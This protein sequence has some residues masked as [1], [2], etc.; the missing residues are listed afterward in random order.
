MRKFAIIA[1]IFIPLAFSSPALAANPTQNANVVH[2]V[3]ASE[4]LSGIASIYHVTV[5]DIVNYNKLSNPDKLQIGQT[6]LIPGKNNNLSTP[7]AKNNE[8]AADG[9]QYEK[10]VVK[11][12]DTFTSIART[13]GV[14]IAD[15]IAA[16]K[17]VNPNALQI[18]Q[19]LLI[20]VSK[21]NQS[22]ASRKDDRTHD[23][24]DNNGNDPEEA[25]A[26]DLAAEIIDYAEEFLGYPYSYAAS[27]PDSFDC[28][29]F[30]RFVFSHFEIDL[31]HSSADQA[32]EGDRVKQRDLI[33]GDLVF[34]KT[35]GRGISHVGIYI[36]DGDFIHASTTSKG[37]IISALS[38]EYYESRYVTAR[39]V[40]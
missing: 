13:E 38:E 24:N 26:D 15:I 6:L 18:G 12:R 25:E 16:N 35:S 36:G 10:Y 20:P 31:P 7:P 3:K 22:L 33:P 30:I 1:A 28:S 9:T 37:V 5:Q 17:T 34:F 32:D 11:A 14:A 8:G 40:F 39:R 2:V 21:Q 19:T 23:D 4:T 29:G 27:G